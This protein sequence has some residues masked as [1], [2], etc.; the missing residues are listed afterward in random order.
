MT[1]HLTKPPSLFTL[2]CMS[3][4]SDLSK[5]NEHINIARTAMEAGVW[6]HASPTYNRGFTFMILRMAFDEARHRVPPMIIK[7]R[8]APAKLLRFEVDDALLRLKLDRIDVAQLVFTETGGFRPLVDD[9]QS[10]GPIREVCRKLRDEGKVGQFCPQID[11]ASSSALAPLAQ[12]GA[13]DGFVL[14]LNPLERD[15]DDA[16]WNLL[17]RQGT[18]LWALRTVAGALGESS[19][20]LQHRAKHPD[21]PNIPLAS[22]ISAIAAASGVGGWTDFC[23]RYARS[24]PHLQTTIGGTADLAH[25]QRFLE[26]ATMTVALPNDVMLQVDSVRKTRAAKN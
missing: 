12:S 26:A 25:L 21:D 23:L 7:I 14:Y 6:F 19:R 16:V 4:G 24:V 22:K 5:I 2:G 9:F 1:S 10:G 3:L 18:P 17:Q 15:V 20:L 8:C 13:F 11:L